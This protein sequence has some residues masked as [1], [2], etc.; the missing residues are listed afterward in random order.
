M[1]R[2]GYNGGGCNAVLRTL[3]LLE[4]TLDC[5]TA[6]GAGHLSIHRE[7]WGTRKTMRRG[8]GIGAGVYGIRTLTSNL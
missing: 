2:L 5:A 3:S 8:S 1:G 6:A 7:T 4:N